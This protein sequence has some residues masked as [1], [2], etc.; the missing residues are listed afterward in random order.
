M[1]FDLETVVSAQYTPNICNNFSQ[2]LLDYSKFHVMNVVHW[3]HI[4]VVD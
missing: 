1:I 3:F 4:T 2:P